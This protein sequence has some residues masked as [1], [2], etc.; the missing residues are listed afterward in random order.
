[1]LGSIKSMILEAGY[2]SFITV[3]SVT[4][5]FVTTPRLRCPSSAIR[6][7]A[8]H[9]ATRFL[10]PCSGPLGRRLRLRDWRQYS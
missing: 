9:A 8:S 1:M 3:P 6:S 4:G 5:S 7:L 10:N 2:V